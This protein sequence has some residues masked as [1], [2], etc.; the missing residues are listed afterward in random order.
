MNGANIFKSGAME[1]EPKKNDIRSWTLHRL[2]MLYPFL[3]LHFTLSN[4]CY[5][6]YVGSTT[7]L[8]CLGVVKP[9]TRTQ[10]RIRILLSLIYKTL[11]WGVATGASTSSTTCESILWLTPFKLI[12]SNS[13]GND[14]CE[15]LVF[16]D[17][18]CLCILLNQQLVEVSCCG[19]NY[20][21]DHGREKNT[22]KDL[23]PGSLI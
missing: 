20:K 13:I 7:F 19:R 1:E 21:Q 12:E 9:Q 10:Q 8:K 15:I 2:Q 6:V 14:H 11:C 5:Q 22:T 23:N 4:K 17:T 18:L 3:F 16:S